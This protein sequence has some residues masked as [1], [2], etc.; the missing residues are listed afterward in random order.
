M[1]S[2]FPRQAV[3]L[4]GPSY[5]LRYNPIIQSKISASTFQKPHSRWFNAYFSFVEHV[6]GFWELPYNPCPLF[7]TFQTTCLGSFGTPGLQGLKKLQPY[8]RTFRARVQP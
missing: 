4:L 7:G 1:F 8:R 2:G 5:N 6:Q 3:G